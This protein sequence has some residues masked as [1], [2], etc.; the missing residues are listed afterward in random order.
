[1]RRS[2][3]GLDTTGALTQPPRTVAPAQL[4]LSAVQAA[5]R[6]G[7][8][9]WPMCEVCGTRESIG[10][11]KP[12]QLS[13]CTR[14]W[15]P[16]LDPVGAAVW[17]RIEA[18]RQRVETVRVTSDVLLP[19]QPSRGDKEDVNGTRRGEIHLGEFARLQRVIDCAAGNC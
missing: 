14:C 12:G 10:P 2:P 5:P 7:Y 6:L 3:S 16:V 9:G 17:D 4:E 1:M 8:R 15:T 13:L 18:Q 11:P 19:P